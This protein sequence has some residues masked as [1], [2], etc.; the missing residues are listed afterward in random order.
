[1]GLNPVRR[2]QRLSGS[3][4]QDHEGDVRKHA[5]RPPRFRKSHRNRCSERDEENLDNYD[6]DDE[7]HDESSTFAKN[8][9][10]LGNPVVAVVSQSIQ[11]SK[12]VNDTENTGESSTQKASDTPL[13]FSSGFTA[14]EGHPQSMDQINNRIDHLSR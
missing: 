14:S 2:Y 9:T 3:A 5:F 7:D 11:Q 8:N 4:S 13:H 10:D 1:M 12:D 6:E